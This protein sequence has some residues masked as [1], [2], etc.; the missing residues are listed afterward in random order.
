MLHKPYC[1]SPFAFA[2][3]NSIPLCLYCQL[4]EAWL[5]IPD[6]G[7]WHSSLETLGTR[8][9]KITSLC[10]ENQVAFPSSCLH[11]WVLALVLKPVH[12]WPVDG[13]GLN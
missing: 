3:K 7:K 13:L 11:W 12:L 6:P 4:W 5:C 8:E 2:V 9:V 10:P 1:N